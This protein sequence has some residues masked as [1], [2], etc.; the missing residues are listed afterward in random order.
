[1]LGD[2]LNMRHPLTGGGMTA[3]FTDI[4]NL[5]NRLKPKVLNSTELTDRAVHKFYNSRHKQNATINILA[6]ALYGVMKNEALKTACY[7]YLKRG[8]TYA[9]EPVA[10]LSAVSRDLGLLMRHFFAVAFFGVRGLLKPFPTPMRIKQSYKL[11]RTAVNILYPLVMN[12]RPN[13]ATRY[14]FKVVNFVFV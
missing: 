13:M 12:E 1:M 14:A 4:Q 2:S 10:I 11:L 7:N 6:D 5:G 3:A 8:G 9:Q